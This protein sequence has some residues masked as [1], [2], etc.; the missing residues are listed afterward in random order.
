MGD[1]GGAAPRLAAPRFFVA[2]AAVAAEHVSLTEEQQHQIRR[3]LRL[4]PGDP[5]IACDGSGDEIVATLT[6]AGRDVWAVPVE[7]RQGRAI[8]SRSVWLYQSALRGDR[9]TWLLQ[10]GTEVG[11]AGFVPV[12]FQRTQSADYAGRALR[13]QA[14]AREAAEQSERATLPHVWDVQP[15]SAAVSSCNPAREL[16]LLLDERERHRSL[17]AALAPAI[18]VVRLFIGP[19]GGL[20][21]QERQLAQLQGL[22]PVSLGSAIL[23]SETA[24]LAA[25]ILALGAS[26]DLG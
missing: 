4:R 22:L 2:P 3:V 10:K 23:R 21:E 1:P 7:R 11:V 17:R 8:P 19:E 12:L 20:T 13:Y 5:I 18:S 6:M 26:E 14:I 25:A 15:F 16:C 9:F 24:G